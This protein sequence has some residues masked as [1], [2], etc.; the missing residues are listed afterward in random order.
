MSEWVSVKEKYPG[1]HEWVLYYSPED[2]LVS[3]GQFNGRSW[4][5]EQ[6]KEAYAATHWMPLP[7][8]PK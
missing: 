3:I 8:R 5:T 6:N 4:W 7:E 2:M 1:L